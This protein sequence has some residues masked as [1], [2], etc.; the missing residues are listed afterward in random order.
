MIVTD[1]SAVVLALADD[2][3]SGDAARQRLDGQR[4]IAPELLDVE[5]ISAWRRHVAAGLLDQGRAAMARADLREMPVERVSH[6]HLMERCWELRDN[7]TVYDACYVALAEVL[8]VPLLTAD[9]RLANAPA[10]RCEIEV[11]N[12]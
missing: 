9:Q 3:A 6:R 8:E 1:A 5:V 11:L 4:L 10:T 2:G 7:L 12:P